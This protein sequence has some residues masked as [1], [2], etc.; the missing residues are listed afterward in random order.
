[1]ASSY[2]SKFPKVKYN[3]NLSVNITLRAKVAESFKKIA[4][5]FYPYTIEDGQTADA[6][7][8]DYYDDP[9]FVWLI[10]LVN[11][12]LDPYYDWPLSTVNFEK[13]I[14]KKYGSIAAAKAKTAYYK[15]IPVDYYINLKDNT[16]IEASLNPGL[17]NSSDWV[18]KTIDDDIKISA[19]SNPNPAIWLQ[20]DCYTQELED[21]EN[22]RYIKLLDKRLLHNFNSQF[23]EMLNG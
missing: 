3:N 20:I 6:L 7:S 19:I 5:N 16:F 2:F 22:K 23:E 8:Y 14:I 10:Y 1:M 4:T 12:I 15:K 11:D 21:N 13:Y 17:A 18:L 9:N